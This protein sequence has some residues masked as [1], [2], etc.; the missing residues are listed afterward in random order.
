MR[1]V[2]ECLTGYQ[3]GLMKGEI[4]LI[5][6]DAHQFDN[7][8]GWMSIVQLDG[9]LVSQQVK[10]LIMCLLEPPDNILN[11]GR[12]EEVLLLDDVSLNLLRCHCILIEED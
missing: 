3:P 6:K 1:G 2:R 10:F 8:Y 7:S 9:N 5:N 4:L 12:T 11:A